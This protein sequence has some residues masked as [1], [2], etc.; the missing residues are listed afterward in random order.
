MSPPWIKSFLGFIRKPR[1]SYPENPVDPV[2]GE[3]KEVYPTGF[4]PV[5]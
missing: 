5:E 2:K 4:T 1:K 3:F